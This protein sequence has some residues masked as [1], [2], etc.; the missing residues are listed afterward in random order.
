MVKGISRQVIVVHAPEQKMFEEVIFILRD[1]VRETGGVSDQ[2][3]LQQ[4]QKLLRHAQPK[5]KMYRKL[6]PIF[7]S[8]A[9]AMLTSAIWLIAWM[10]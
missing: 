7:W 5:R 8:F 10:L 1:E 3:L 6:Q 9:G 4:A 2:E